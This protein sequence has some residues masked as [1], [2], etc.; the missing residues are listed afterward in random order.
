MLSVMLGYAFK[1]KIIRSN[2]CRLV[3]KMKDEGRKVKI[4]TIDEIEAIFPA[5]WSDVW[6]DYRC[7]VINMVAACTGMRIGEIMGLRSEFVHH[8]YLEVCGQYSL[9]AG[10]SDVKTHK[11]REVPVH[12]A[13]ESHLRR[14]IRENGEGFVF[15]TKPRAV[16]PMGRTM[17]IQSFWKALEAIGIH[18]EQR[19]ERNLTFHSWRHFFNT[20]LLTNNVTDSKVMEVIG[21]LTEKSRK[22]YTQFDATQFS[23]V[24]EAQKTL[25]ERRGGKKAGAGT[26]KAKKAESVR[27]P[28]V[29]KAGTG[30]VKK[31]GAAKGPA[32]KKSR[33]G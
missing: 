15:V 17:V 22:R 28:A 21:H 3:E 29:K 23:E 33:A 30:T 5:R 9:T 32:V 20:Y 19:R 27:G 8:G 11:P 26:A 1:Q 6:D 4:L 18:E 12:A 10:Y 14:L 2:P 7:Y 31:T 24:I 16:K 13:V 25:L